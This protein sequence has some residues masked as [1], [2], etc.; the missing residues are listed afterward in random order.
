MKRILTFSITFLFLISACVFFQQG[1]TGTTPVSSPPPGSP[2]PTITPPATSNPT[3]S[4]SPQLATGTQQVS[5]PEIPPANAPCPDLVNGAVTFSPDGIASRLVYL[6]VGSGSGGPL[7]F[8]WH[9]AGGQ[10]QNAPTGLGESVVSAITAQGG[11]VASIEA[12]P[13]MGMAEWYLNV[14]VREDDLLVADLVTAC[15]VQQK[16]IDVTH[17]HVVGFSAGG[18]QAAQM[19]IRRSAYVASV[20]LYSGGLFPHQLNPYPPYENPQN[21]FPSMV[22]WGGPSDVVVADNTRAA[23]DYYDFVSLNGNFTLMCNHNGGHIIPAAAPA[24]AWRF[25]QD[26]PWGVFP[27]PY[28]T[29]IPVEIP[30]YCVANP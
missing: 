13:E 3:Q 4:A 12:D 5:A 28:L 16:N 8:W 22:F 11:V 26:H 19:A 6:W 30:S 18:K 9:G 2:S 7:V 14:F 10:A 1:N 29:E 23:Q 24:A 20:V 17:I 25:F 21:R 15:A 27:E